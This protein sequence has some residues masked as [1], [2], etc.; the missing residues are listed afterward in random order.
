MP[1]V[2]P[3]GYAPVIIHIEYMLL[4]IGLYVFLQVRGILLP[5]FLEFS[6]FLNYS[7]T[8]FLAQRNKLHPRIIPAPCVCKIILVGVAQYSTV[9]LFEQCLS[10]QQKYVYTIA[11]LYSD[12]EAN[13]QRRSLVVSWLPG[14]PPPPQQSDS[15]ESQYDL[16]ARKPPW[17]PDSIYRY[18]IILRLSLDL[19]PLLFSL[20]L[21][22]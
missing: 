11:H 2:P 4:Y 16:A 19:L 18:K 20:V 22:C 7:L 10:V 9:L 3:S 5:Y 6:P 8:D 21:L 17:L 15:I 13:L 14:T 1:P 12:S